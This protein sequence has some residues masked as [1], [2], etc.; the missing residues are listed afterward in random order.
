[1]T[2]PMNFCPRH[3]C[4]YKG[5]RIGEHPDS[6]VCDH[7]DCIKTATVVVLVRPDATHTIVSTLLP[8]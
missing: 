8:S 6:F 3:A 7:A 5:E 4:L 1:M 2:L